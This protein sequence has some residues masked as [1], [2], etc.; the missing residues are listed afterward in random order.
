MVT[1]IKNHQKE[2]K[3]LCRQ[4]NVQRLEIFGSAASGE[5]FDIKTSDIDFL[6]EFLPTNPREHSRAYFGLLEALQDMFAR[7]IDLV[8]IKAVSNPYLMESINENRSSI[9]AA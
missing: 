9:Y 5:G 3:N 1:L 2:L 7:P 6:V 8:E 4:Y